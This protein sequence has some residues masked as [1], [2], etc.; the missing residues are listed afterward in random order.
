MRKY[1]SISMVLVT[2]FLTSTVA[3][4]Q[5]IQWQ[6]FSPKAFDL[7]K[8][9]HRLIF[10]NVYTEWCH[11]CKQMK[12]TYQDSSVVNLINQNFIPVKVDAD[13]NAEVIKRY[14]VSDL[15]SALILDSDYKVINTV[16]GYFTPDEFI[17]KLNEVIAH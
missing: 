9:Q 7:A 8:K 11:W 17:A 13:K 4:A 5:T 15:P 1:I 3:A 14:K 2:L 16:N 12:N 6:S 10:V